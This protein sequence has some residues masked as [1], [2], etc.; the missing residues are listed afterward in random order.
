MKQEIAKAWSADLRDPANKQA[1]GV[2]FDGEC[3][4]PLGRLC[5][6]LGEKFV[7]SGEL[8]R[9][10]VEGTESWQVLPFHV[11]DKA[12]MHTLSGAFPVTENRFVKLSAANDAG[13]T[14][15]QIADLVD[16]F[17]EDL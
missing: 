2:L 6:V 13:L 3:Y 14:F 10:V 9:Y 4:C 17:A 16:Y 11:M 5:V 15:P 1:S 7:W 12:G 8:V